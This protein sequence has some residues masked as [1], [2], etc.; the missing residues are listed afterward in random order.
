MTEQWRR[1]E[2]FD[3]YEVSDLGRVRSWAVRGSFGIGHL[4]K[5]PKVLRANIDEDGYRWLRLASVPGRE[6]RFLV[7][8]LVAAAFIGPAPEDKPL[9]CHRNGDP[10]DN[11][12][13]NL[14]YDT[15]LGNEADKVLHGTKL[16]GSRAPM[17]KLTE[18]EV[19][20]I[21]R[22]YAA[23]GVTQRAL[24]AEYGVTGALVHFITRRKIWTHV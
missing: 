11:R 15:T 14:R 8:R 18:P 4:A 22:R 24:G 23:G 13:E 10:T 5:K 6:T 19:I 17:A 16:F 3:R 7:H 2:G 21:R 1:I 20:E 12:P 9:V